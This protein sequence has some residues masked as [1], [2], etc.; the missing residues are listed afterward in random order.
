MHKKL[1]AELV[2]LAH[3]ILELENSDV[4]TLH[5]KAKDIYEKLTVL[6]FVE[7]N[8]DQVLV[9]EEDKEDVVEEEKVVEFT[10][11]LKE[12]EEEILPQVEESFDKEPVEDDIDE[13]VSLMDEETSAT[14]ELEVEQQEFERIEEPETVFS[15]EENE[16]KNDAEDIAM[17]FTLESEFED[18]I[19]ADEATEMFEKATKESPVIE[20]KPSEQKRSLNDSLFKGNIQVGLNDR[21]AFVKHLFDGSQEDFNRVL[22]QLNSFDSEREAKSFI[23]KMVKPDYNWNEKDEYEERLLNLIERKFM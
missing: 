7:N 10:G 23:N 5:Q 15:L 3:S 6:K 11:E 4:N 2:S 8:L 22:S 20:E 13:E 12:V 18:A 21:I 1:A 19:S 17:Q 16:V 14:I 9:V